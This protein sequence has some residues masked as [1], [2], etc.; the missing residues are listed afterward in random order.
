MTVDES[1]SLYPLTVELDLPAGSI[2]AFDF[3]L[4]ASD[5]GT[6]DATSGSDYA[7]FAP[8][9]CVVP[10]G[11]LVRTTVDLEVQVIDDAI[12]RG[13]S[14]S[15]SARSGADLAHVS[16]G[17]IDAA[18]GITDDEGGRLLLHGEL[19]RHGHRDA[20]RIGRWHRT[21]L[22]VDGPDNVGTSSSSGTR[23]GRPRLGRLARGDR[24]SER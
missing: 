15:R 16:G 12:P 11:D 9:T 14:S 23:V 24:R 21:R 13:T 3:V 4:V 7:A 5:D 2:L 10:Y 6:G 17:S 1:A 19:G 8:Q 22:E 18:L 20:P